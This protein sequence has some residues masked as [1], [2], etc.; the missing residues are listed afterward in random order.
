MYESD[1]CRVSTGDEVVE[2][3]TV[4]LGP[5]QIRDAGELMSCFKRATEVWTCSSPLVVF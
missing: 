1:G 3:E 5:G 2:P 4:Q